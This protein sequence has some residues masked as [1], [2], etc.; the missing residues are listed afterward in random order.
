M[1]LP[2]FIA[3]RYLFA[4]KSHNVINI[5]SI[6]S[7]IGIAV[8]SCALIMVLSIYNGFEHVVKSMYDRAMPDI[9]VTCDTSRYFRTDSE[10]F[11]SVRSLPGIASFN[12]SIEETVFLTYGREEGTASLKGVERSYTEEPELRS[13]IVEGDFDLMHGDIAEAVTG[14]RLAVEMGIMSRFL[15]PIEV[16]FPISDGEISL[17]NP[18]SSLNKETFYPT[19]TFFSGGGNYDNTLFV[20]IERARRLVGLSDN[21]AGTVELRL[22]DGA[23][24]SRTVK[25]IRSILGPGFSVKDKYMQNETV[26]RMMRIE[27]AVIFMILLFIIIV[28][29]C[30]V[31]GSLTM[32]IIEK[33]DDIA[34]LQHLGARRSLIRR[35]FF[36]EG[37]MIIMLGA[38]IGIAVGIGLCLIQQYVG[39]IRMPGSFVV[40]Y[41]PVVIKPLDILITLA[42]IAL[43]GLVITALPTRRTLSRIL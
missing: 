35:I 10:A 18:A 31:F 39:V 19:G 6:I 41:Y 22:D 4:K 12:Q 32:L 21:E 30:N 42:G 15:D 9:A 8:G 13:C 2:Y 14:R 20:P 23:D 1:H 16:Y 38:V 43:I 25:E 27:K 40:K 28:V 17:V 3:R 33:R 37:W 29:S 5:I 36:D 24:I 11:R 26:Y 34:T 7:S